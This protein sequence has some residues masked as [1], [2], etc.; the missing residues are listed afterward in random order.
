[1]LHAPDFL[2]YAGA[3]EMARDHREIVEQGLQMKKAGNALMAVVGG[4]E[5]H[6]INVRVGGFYRAPTRAELRSLVDPLERARET[7]LATVRWAATLPF[8]DVERRTRA[9]G[10]V[11][12]GGLPD[13]PRSDPSPTAVW[14]SRRRSSTTTSSRSTS[15]TPTRCTRASASAAPI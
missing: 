12:S 15:S 3:V 8:P 5:I 11:R 6:P 4:R 10:A 13:R 14:T 1:M 9:A 2:G 7:A